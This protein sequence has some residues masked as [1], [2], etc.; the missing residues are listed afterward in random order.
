MIILSVAHKRHKPSGVNGIRNSLEDRRPGRAPQIRHE[1][2]DRIGTP[3]P[4]SARKM[5]WLIA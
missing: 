1:N 5:I 2:T 3:T 4:E